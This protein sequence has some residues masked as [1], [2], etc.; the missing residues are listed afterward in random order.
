MSYALILRSQKADLKETGDAIV[1]VGSWEGSREE[2][3]GERVASGY[4]WV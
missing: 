4:I 1:G 3:D 2:R